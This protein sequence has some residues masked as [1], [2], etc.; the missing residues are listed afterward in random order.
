VCEADALKDETA[1]PRAGKGLER[2]HETMRLVVELD[3]GPSLG[4]RLACR[5]RRFL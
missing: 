3:R 4:R 2:L 1:F 5:T